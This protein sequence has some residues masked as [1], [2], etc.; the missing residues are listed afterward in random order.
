MTNG[1]D[2][3]R[4]S[5]K[6]IIT[7]LYRVL[8]SI[9]NKDAHRIASGAIKE[10]SAG[11]LDMGSQDAVKYESAGS[12]F[13]TGDHEMDTLLNEKIGSMIPEFLDAFYEL[14]KE[15]RE[16]RYKVMG[17]ALDKIILISESIRESGTDPALA[18]EFLQK[19][20]DSFSSPAFSA[21]LDNDQTD[22]LEIMN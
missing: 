21:L 18:E 11:Y 3:W 2:S 5:I 8:A 14:G 1:Y 4:A 13:K 16:N 17:P 12:E 19:Y 6:T 15:A 9:D 20:R 7:N 10:W 22:L